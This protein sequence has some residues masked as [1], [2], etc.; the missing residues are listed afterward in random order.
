MVKHDQLA[1]M[2]DNY[3]M[4]VVDVVIIK[5]VRGGDVR[6]V[7]HTKNDIAARLPSAMLRSIGKL[8]Y[9]TKNPLDQ[10]CVV[11]DVTVQAINRGE[12]SMLH[13]AP[14]SVCIF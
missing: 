9:F 3:T 2:L 1:K 14:G 13:V 11:C 10:T 4:E 12:K 8:K 7:K 5:A 6:R